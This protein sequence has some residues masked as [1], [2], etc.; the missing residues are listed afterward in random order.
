MLDIDVEATGAEIGEPLPLAIF[1][2]SGVTD[3][4]LPRPAL[5]EVVVVGTYTT[6]RTGEDWLIP[7]RLTSA[8]EQ[9]RMFVRK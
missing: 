5:D 6:P 3:L 4:D 1:E 2:P 7:G 8:S 9:T